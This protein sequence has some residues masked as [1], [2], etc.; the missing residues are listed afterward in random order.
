[1]LPNIKWPP[2]ARIF[3]AGVLNVVILALLGCTVKREPDFA[4]ISRL[5]DGVRNH[6]YP[7]LRDAEITIHELHSDYVYLET[8][9]T[10]T[11]YFFSGR[12]RY[13]IFFND[14]AA[15]RQV[16]AEGLR[17]IVAHELAHIDYYQSQSRMGLAGLV[18]ILSPSFNA[19]FERRADL[20][21]I[22]LGYGP[23]LQ[24]Y[25]TW[26]YRN[27]PGDRMAEKKRDYFS[28]GEIAAIL[29]FEKQTPGFISEAMRCIP[30]NAAEIETLARNP[31][32]KC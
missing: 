16:P 2:A 26:L 25:R 24:I 32:L 23:G 9:F 3:L 22:A 8:R 12:L 27:I 6:S 13:M 30:R 21:A 5:V 19:R 29:R 17:A 15:Q 4:A 10:M 7:Q 31:H 1:M 18:R 20:E 14:Q 28:P 11:S